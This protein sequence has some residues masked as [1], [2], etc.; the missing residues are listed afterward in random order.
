MAE[1][2]ALKRD[3]Y[4]STDAAQSKYLTIPIGIRKSGVVRKLRI[5][6]LLIAIRGGLYTADFSIFLSDLFQPAEWQDNPDVNI[7]FF[8][9]HWGLGM[10]SDRFS[11]T[12]CLL[13][14]IAM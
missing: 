11:R 12:C 8:C 6:V 1:R 9:C 2:M 13:L 3:D 4:D 5:C 7:G 14:Q 10:L